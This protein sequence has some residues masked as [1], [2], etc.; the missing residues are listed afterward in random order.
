VGQGIHLRQK[1]IIVSKTSLLLL[2]LVAAIP[3]SILAILMVMTLLKRA[4]EMSGA[5]L[6][7]SGVTLACAAIITLTPVGIALF[8]P[9]TN[10]PESEEGEQPADEELVEDEPASF[11]DPIPAEFQ[12]EEGLSNRQDVESSDLDTVEDGIGGESVHDEE[13]DLSEELFADAD[14]GLDEIDFDLDED[15]EDEDKEQT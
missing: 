10:R 1:G 4:N 2:S 6:G 11:A 13:D 8:T 15:E 3:G 7:L 14:E 5:M 9:K 12:M